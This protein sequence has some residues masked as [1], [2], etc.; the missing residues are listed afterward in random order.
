M[1]CKFVDCV[2]ELPENAQRDAV[3]LRC[4]PSCRTSKDARSAHRARPDNKVRATGS[5]ADP[6]RESENAHKGHKKT[7]TDI[8]PQHFGKGPLGEGHT[9]SEGQDEGEGSFDQQVR[10][11]A[12]DGAAGYRLVLPIRAQTESPRIIPSAD[13]GGALRYYRLD[14][15]E[16]PDD[17]RLQ[18]GHSYRILW[19]DSQGQPL[20][21]KGT[22][23]CLRCMYFLGR[24]MQISGQ[25]SQL[26]VSICNWISCFSRARRSRNS[27]VL[28][29]LGARW[30]S[31]LI[32]RWCSRL[33]R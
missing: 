32:C 6:E 33:Q 12:P 19:V 20:A 11:Q 15:F 3:L 13:A 22:Q 9:C 21:R 27:A 24:L 14:P 25:R 7:T 28:I 30:E 17:L 1:K 29:Y 18:D 8:G 2:N 26:R 4:M 31:G 16:L 23:T 5:S 10:S